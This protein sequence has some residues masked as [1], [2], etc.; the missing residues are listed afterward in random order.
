MGLI[1]LG[2]FKMKQMKTS[3]ARI[4]VQSSFCV[5]CSHKIKAA[6]LEI[7]DISNVRLYP[8]DALV[9]FNFV[10]ANEISKALNVLTSLGYPEE[11]EKNNDDVV[12][13]MCR[14]N[15]HIAATA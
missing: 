1:Y 2:F 10:R 7:D 9:V 13:P 11:G 8:M 15:E 5:R 12:I 4:P 3:I 14:C 6:L